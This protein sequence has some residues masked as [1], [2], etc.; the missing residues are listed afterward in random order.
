MDHATSNGH[1]HNYHLIL[2]SSVLA[3]QCSWAEEWT[4][5]KPPDSP[6]LPVTSVECLSRPRPRPAAGAAPAGSALVRSSERDGERARVGCQVSDVHGDMTRVRG[7][8]FAR[9]AVDE[10]IGW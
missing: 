4:V 1:L 7:L 2:K 3:S 10:S 5:G 9:S 6:A 8:A